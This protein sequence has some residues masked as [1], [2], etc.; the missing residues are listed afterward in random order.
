MKPMDL[1]KKKTEIE[2]DLETV[3]KQ[4]ADAKW[5]QKTL[6]A[7]LRKVNNLIEKANEILKDELKG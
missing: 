6:E 5:Q 1:N 7:Q 3:K 4:I 2:A